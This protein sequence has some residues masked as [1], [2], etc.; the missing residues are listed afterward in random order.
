MRAVRKTPVCLRPGIDP[1]NEQKAPD[2]DRK[3]RVPK[4]QEKIQTPSI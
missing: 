2:H 1:G 4:R 3:H